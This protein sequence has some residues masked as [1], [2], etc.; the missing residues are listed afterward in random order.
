MPVYDISAAAEALDVPVKQLD[1]ILS[2]N[3]VSGV[4]RRRRGVTRRI[5]ADAVFTIRLALDLQHE[6]RSPFGPALRLAQSLQ[7]NAGSTALG[8]FANLSVDL[9]ALHTAM[10]ARL[11]GAVETVGRR[12]RGRPPRTVA[13]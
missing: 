9:D 13:P 11:D 10:F 2:R 5:T 7:E 4:E 12:P 6:L 3:V 8:A 1:N